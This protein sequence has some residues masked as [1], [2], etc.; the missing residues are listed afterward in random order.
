MGLSK[1]YSVGGPACQT[2]CKAALGERELL[3]NEN[4]KQKDNA[5][6]IY[7]VYYEIPVTQN[8]NLYY[9]SY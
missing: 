9:F 8:V 1:Y 2:K 5:V 4:K 7:I 6:I 3:F